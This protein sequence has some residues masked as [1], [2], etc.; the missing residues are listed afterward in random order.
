MPRFERHLRL[1]TGLV[2]V[3]LDTLRFAGI[4]PPDVGVRRVE[5]RGR[6][7]QLEVLPIEDPATLLVPADQ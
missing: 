4:S 7:G 2:I 6:A 5:V 3:S 1:V